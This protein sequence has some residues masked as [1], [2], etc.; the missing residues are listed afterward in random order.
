MADE[1]DG[2][3]VC[4]RGGALVADQPAAG[5]VDAGPLDAGG[6]VS[7]PR[8][9]YRCRPV[10]PLASRRCDGDDPLAGMPSL[11][12]VT[13]AEAK[14][15]AGRGAGRRHGRQ[16]QTGPGDDLSAARTAAWWRWRGREC[17]VGPS[18]RRNIRGRDEVYGS[19]WRS[20]V[21][22]LVA[23]VGL[24]PFERMAVRTDKVTYSSDE[25]AS[26]TLLVRDSQ[27][28]GPTPRIELLRRH[29]RSSLG[30]FPASRG[31]T[32][33]AS[34]SRPGATPEGALPGPSGRR[35]ERGNLRRG[36]LRRTRQSEGAAR[37]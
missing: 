28:G 25:N 12:T 24:L 30:G 31:A 5:R 11:A 17:G 3:L 6:R 14:P 8:A 36:G 7:F 13:G 34:S 20:L 27:A 19:L 9:A 33:R 18:Y 35:R 1:K 32:R 4:F 2:S 10:A 23:N 37:R 29:G 15:A 26:A 22:W 16:G 21:R